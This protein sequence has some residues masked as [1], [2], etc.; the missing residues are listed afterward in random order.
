[1]AGGGESGDDGEEIREEEERIYFISTDLVV[2]DVGGEEDHDDGDNDGKIGF[3]L[4][5]DTHPGTIN[6]SLLSTRWGPH[7]Q[8]SPASSPEEGGRGPFGCG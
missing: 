1:M 8:P 2:G 4:Q 6:Y 5:G 3:S 7:S